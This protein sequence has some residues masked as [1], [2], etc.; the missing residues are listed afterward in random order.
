MQFML[1][2]H[3]PWPEGIEPRQVYDQ[4]T[5]QIQ[6]AEELGFSSAWLAEHHFSRYGLGASQLM[7]LAKVASQTKRIH[8]GTAIL[9]PPLHHPIS[10]AED[11]AMLDQISGG[12]VEIG[13]GRGAAGYE[14]VGYGVPH[15]ESQARFQETIQIVEGLLTT[16]DYSYRG[17]FYDLQH[18]NLAP[19]P[20]QTPH[21]PIYIAATRT[22][23]TLQF[24]GSSGHPIIVG[25]V[26]DHTDALDLCHRFLE[27][28]AAAGH[29]MSMSRIPFFR[30]LYVAESAEQARRDTR[31]AM[32]WT[33]D[34]IQWRG[35]ISSG[36]EVYQRIEDF[37]STRTTRPPS[38][39]HIAEHRALFGTPDVILERISALRAEGLEYF[40]CNFAFGTMPHE[41]VM[42]SMEL[43]AREVMPKLQ[44]EAMPMKA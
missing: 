37:R 15:A 39:E 6:Y 11:I 28:A 4:A 14:Y 18:V 32:E 13:F 9:V 3:L 34:M 30:Y 2:S 19:P 25:V 42:R 16:P 7:L 33:Q 31:E 22:P 35:V 21:P 5:E 8:L 36:S 44:A 29:E 1:F 41:K 43:F 10:L 27:L 38:Y 26:L 12:R 17:R 23:T 20:L 40:G 24:V